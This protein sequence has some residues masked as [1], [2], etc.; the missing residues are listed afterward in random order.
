[1]KQD[2]TLVL[3]L[4]GRPLTYCSAE[5]AVC[6]EM[7]NRVYVIKTWGTEHVIRSQFLV[8]QK[9]CVVMIKRYVRINEFDV[10]VLTRRKLFQ[11][12]NGLCQYCGG[13]A[14]NIDHVVP[15][16]LGGRHEWENV[17]ASCI[18]CNIKKGHKALRDSGLSLRTI[19]T[20][21]TGTKIYNP[22]IEEWEEYWT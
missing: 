14:E 12:D 15:R 18:P 6:L 2:R 9:P 22:G 20:V 19:P 21:P 13:Q 16:K 17:V 3:N 5:R 7:E 1:M 4:D 8:I 11:R 10:P